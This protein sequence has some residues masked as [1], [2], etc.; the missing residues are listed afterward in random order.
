MNQ[1]QLPIE[2]KQ[3]GDFPSYC[4][5]VSLIYR[6]LSDQFWGMAYRADPPMTMEELAMKKVAEAMAIRFAER[7]SELK[8]VANGAT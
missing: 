2:D 4:G 7:A 8:A 1:Q 6:D 3:I 5:L